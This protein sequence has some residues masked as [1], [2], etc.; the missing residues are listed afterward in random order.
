VDQNV[1]EIQIVN[2]DTFARARDVLSNQIHVTPIHVD[3]EQSVQLQGLA[4]PSVDV[5]QDSFQILI[6]SLD[7]NLNVSLTLTV[8]EVSFARVRDVL[9]N[10]IH[11]I[12]LHV[13][14]EQFVL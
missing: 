7:A 9:R 12:L 11:V 13:V 3:L 1:S 5:N 6:P 14:Q 8:R 10:Q 2:R 4:M